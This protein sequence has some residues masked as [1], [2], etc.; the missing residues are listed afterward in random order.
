MWVC[1]VLIGI[2][3]VLFIGHE[4]SSLLIYMLISYF[5]TRFWALCYCFEGFLYI[6]LQPQLVMCFINIF[7]SLWFA[8]FAFLNVMLA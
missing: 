2:F 7:A 1:W 6:S 8:M 3:L 4:G 5:S